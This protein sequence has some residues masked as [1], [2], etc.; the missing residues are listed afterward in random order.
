MRDGIL[1]VHFMWVDTHLVINRITLLLFIGLVFQGCEDDRVTP[2]CVTDLGVNT[3]KELNDLRD[4]KLELYR[5]A[6]SIDTIQFYKD[7]LST[8]DN[9][10]DSTGCTEQTN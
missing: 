7:Q 4:E 1:I 10:I 6:T 2:K 9:C 5:A 3:C 8:I